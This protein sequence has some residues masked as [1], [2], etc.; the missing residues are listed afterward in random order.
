M[1]SMIFV[2]VKCD[3]TIECCRKHNFK[4]CHTQVIPENVRN[5]YFKEKVFRHKEIN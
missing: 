5:I 1:A 3:P 4:Y 2:A